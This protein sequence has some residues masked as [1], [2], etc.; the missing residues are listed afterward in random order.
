MDKKEAGLAVAQKER[1]EARKTAG[2]GG[3]E[4][5]SVMSSRSE[6]CC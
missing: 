1:W 3:K 4:T 5:V 2:Q 6:D